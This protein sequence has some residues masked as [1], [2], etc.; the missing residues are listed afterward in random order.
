MCHT[1]P[2]FFL[3]NPAY[4]GGLPEITE[5]RIDMALSGSGIRDPARGLG[6]STDTVL[7]ALNK[8][9]RHSARCPPSARLVEPGCGEG[10][11]V[12]R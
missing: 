6:I 4:Q 10:C 12:A 7:N 3:L 1:G 11:H 5:Q 8:K 9:S 2:P